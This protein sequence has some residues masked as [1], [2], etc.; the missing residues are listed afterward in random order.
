MAKTAKKHFVGDS[1]HIVETEFSD[2]TSKVAESVFSQGNEYMGARGFLD[3]GTTAPTLRD[4][5][6]NGVYEYSLDE[7][8]T[9]YKGISKRAHYMVNACNFF[10]V[11]IYCGSE[12]L[13]MNVSEY[14]DY[15]RCYNLK[16]GVLT[17]S[18]TW[19][20]GEKRIKLD[21]ERFFDM[22][23]YKR[24]YQRIEFASNEP[25][26]IVLK[27]NVHFNGTHW[28]QP[29]RWS[30][31]EC[32]ANGIECVTQ[33]TNQRVACAQAVEIDGKEVKKEH[34]DKALSTTYE[35]VLDGKNVAKFTRFVV[36]NVKKDGT[37]AQKGIDKELA[38]QVE[39][40]YQS[41]LAR[42]AEYWREFWEKS[43][44]EIEGD[45]DNQQGI[46]F[47]ISQLQQTYHGIDASNNIGAKGLT[48]EAY[49]GQTFWDTE[50]YCL[51]YYLYN[52]L[53]AAKYLLEY[54]YSTLNQARA[55]ARDLDCEGACYPI[56]TIN[57]EESCTLW[58]HAS[59]QMQPSTG[60]AYGIYHYVTVSGDVEYLYGHGIEMLV[61][62]CRYLA[63]RG[64][65]D[66]NGRYFGYY[67][68][69]GPDEFQMM[70]NHNTYTNYMAKKTFEYTLETLATMPQSAR[71][72][73]SKKLGLSREEK[74]TWKRMASKM[75][76]LF[77]A[78]TGL[79]EQHE[80]YYSL[81]H[82][83]IDQIPDTDFPLYS[84]WS[85]DRI[86]RNDMIKQPDVLMFQLLYSEDFSKEIKRKNYEFYEPRCIHES[87]LSPSVHS[88]IACEIDKKDEAVKFF[89]FASRL[90]LDDYNR[91]TEE[92]LHTTSISAAW[93]NIVYGFGGLRDGKGG[94]G[95]SPMIPDGWQR[96]SFSVMINGANVKVSVDK[97]NVTLHSDKGVNV[98]VYGENQYIDGTLT[99]KLAK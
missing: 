68:V 55:R 43:D 81:P 38:L 20:V 75:K 2:K 24:A 1:W 88:I 87:S 49:S 64:Q 3:E 41:A 19:I 37:S 60:V 9:G 93:L 58:Q 67:A 11:E 27:A 46:R 25:C 7:T 62:I 48:G 22:Q 10:D 12:R 63:T 16:N 72:R 77:N 30:E 69:M 79:Y 54:R 94:I 76:I 65:W 84:H 39:E 47:C 66:H 82:V 17:R 28:G 78:K 6:C 5:Y 92:G 8:S 99:V 74:A 80:G 90:D 57:G 21:F 59:L 32:F 26:T 33:S 31:V 51:P 73:V 15:Q 40:G 4:A 44:I 34:T 29:S 70:V 61:E 71:T 42:T 23:N 83:D 35:I 36:V 14:E 52:N 86:Y 89:E 56:A 97:H 85:Y 18:F 50:T 98:K 91:N 96:Y 95:I 45:E 13:D 53:E